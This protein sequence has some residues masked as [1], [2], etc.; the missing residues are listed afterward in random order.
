MKTKEYQIRQKEQ[1][2]IFIGQALKEYHQQQYNKGVFKSVPKTAAFL[3]IPEHTLRGAIYSNF[4]DYKGSYVTSLH[5]LYDAFR[6]NSSVLPTLL[7]EVVAPT[8]MKI[9]LSTENDSVDEVRVKLK[10]FCRCISVSQAQYGKGYREGLAYRSRV[11]I[12]SIHSALHPEQ[13]KVKMVTYLDILKGMGCFVQFK[14]TQE[15]KE[16]YV[17]QNA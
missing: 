12:S 1:M 10:D 8:G 9:E 13:T 2:M 17:C 7:I 3:N 5:K 16:R 15:V 14:L 6:R 4:D 11:E